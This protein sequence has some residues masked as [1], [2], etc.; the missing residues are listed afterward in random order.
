[1]TKEQEIK[2]GEHGVWWGPEEKFLWTSDGRISLPNASSLE[3]AIA[4]VARFDEGEF[5]CAGCR[6]WH[7]RP[8]A[9]QRFAG[10]YCQSAADLYKAENSRRCRLCG[11]PIW[12]C[13]C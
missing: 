10:L 2:I 12:D 4:S 13:Y 8:A 11:R 3:E 1:M 9:F 5:F 7:D 6:E